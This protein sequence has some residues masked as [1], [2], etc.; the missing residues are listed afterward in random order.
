MIL[1]KQNTA[2][3]VQACVEEILRL[4]SNQKGQRKGSALPLTIPENEEMPKC[5]QEKEEYRQAA[6]GRIWGMAGN[7]TNKLLLNKWRAK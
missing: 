4:T 3:L 5:S 1:I 6:R 2:L 7:S